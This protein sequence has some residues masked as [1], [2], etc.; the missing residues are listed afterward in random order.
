MS[1]K[2]TFPLIITDNS[3]YLNTPESETD[4]TTCKVFA[5]IKGFYQ[6]L[7]AYDENG[8]LWKVDNVLSKYPINRLTKFLAYSFYNPLIEV[9]L[10]WSKRKVYQL[11]YLKKLINEQVNKDDDIL[12]QFADSDIIKNAIENCQSYN[13]VFQTLNKYV[14]R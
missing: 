9:T 5:L 13:K 1:D 3:G 2:P 8:Y 14:F 11:N 4:L 6:K 7:E 10:F 12:T